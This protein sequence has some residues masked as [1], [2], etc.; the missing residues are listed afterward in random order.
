MGNSALFHLSK[1]Y[2]HYFI[3]LK[4]EQYGA[5]L[6]LAWLC[7]ITAIAFLPEIL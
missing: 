7:G 2:S 3:E 5:L 6:V 4:V 1:N